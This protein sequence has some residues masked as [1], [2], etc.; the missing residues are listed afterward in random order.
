MVDNHTGIQV[1]IKYRKLKIDIDIV[2]QSN[3]LQ[4][5]FGDMCMRYK[6]LD[7]ENQ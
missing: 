3:V 4:K 7:L 2:T 1:N 5:Y 6:D